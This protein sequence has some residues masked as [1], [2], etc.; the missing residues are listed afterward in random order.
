MR[1]SI[2]HCEGKLLDAKAA[3]HGKFDRRDRRRA[4]MRMKGPSFLGA[5]PGF[6]SVDELIEAM[7]G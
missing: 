5:E 7:R 6:E 2:E 3:V 1:T 4:Y